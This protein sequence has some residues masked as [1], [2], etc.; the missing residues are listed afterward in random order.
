MCLKYIVIKP[1][2][3]KGDKNNLVNF[4]FICHLPS[5]LKFSKKLCMKITE[6]YYY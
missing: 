4:R 2:S 5:H 1:I 6:T 3:K